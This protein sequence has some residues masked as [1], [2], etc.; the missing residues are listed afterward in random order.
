MEDHRHQFA[1]TLIRKMT[2]VQRYEYHR[3]CELSLEESAILDSKVI[4]QD[5]KDGSE[6]KTVKYVTDRLLVLPPFI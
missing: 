4:V 3:L 2:S 5:E 6:R 1:V